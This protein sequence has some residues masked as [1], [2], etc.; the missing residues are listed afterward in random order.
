M[1]V[2][3]V[4]WDLLGYFEIFLRYLRTIATRLHH[5]FSSLGWRSCA[6]LTGLCL[7]WGWK[8]TLPPF[9]WTHPFFLVNNTFSIITIS[10][11]QLRFFWCQMIAATKMTDAESDAKACISSPLRSAHQINNFWKFCFTFGRPDDNLKLTLPPPGSLFECHLELVLDTPDSGETFLFYVRFGVNLL[12]I[13]SLRWIRRFCSQASLSTLTLWPWRRPQRVSNSHQQP[14]KHISYHISHHKTNQP[15][16][17]ECF[18]KDTL[19]KIKTFTP[20]RNRGI[21]R[22]SISRRRDSTNK[23]RGSL[24]TL[25]V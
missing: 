18:S 10:S 5:F 21:P 20:P 25:K 8:T 14:F 13:W 24:L 17:V 3:R 22:E 23:C 4:I 11:M 9:T 7:V 12:K 16:P 2:S 1:L 19:W 6:G 15:C